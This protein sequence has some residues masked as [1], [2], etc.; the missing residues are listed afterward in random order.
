MYV[1]FLFNVKIEN[2][3]DNIIS[4][5]L[6][7]PGKIVPNEKNFLEICILPTC[8][9]LESKYVIYFMNLII[10]RISLNKIQYIAEGTM[11][12]LK[13]DINF[14]PK[15]LRS[16]GFFEWIQNSH[17]YTHNIGKWY[18]HTCNANLIS[19]T[20]SLYFMLEQ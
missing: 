16:T 18:I 9:Q 20:L 8:I 1:L 13:S 10:S 5:D 7:F 6:I 15:R 2:A 14:L 3:I 4:T 12:W 11:L 17:Y 19:F